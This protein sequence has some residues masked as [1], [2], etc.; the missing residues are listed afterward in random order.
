MVLKYVQQLLLVYSFTESKLL[1]YCEEDSVGC[2]LTVADEDAVTSCS[3]EDAEELYPG[4][5][6]VLVSRGEASPLDLKSFNI[7]H[8]FQRETGEFLSPRKSMW[9]CLRSLDI[10]AEEGDPPPP[11]PPRPHA[12]STH[13]V[14]TLCA[15]M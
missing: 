2:N 6:D 5:L 1:T 9:L 7:K 8:R 12:P 3:N 13:P 14:P 15:C 10:L 11:P 4:E